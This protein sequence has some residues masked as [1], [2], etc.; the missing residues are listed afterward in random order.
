MCSEKD[1]KVKSRLVARGYEEHEL[2]D[3]VDS[4]T[5]SKSNLRLVIAITSAKQW[6]INSLDFHSAFLQGE[7][8]TGDIFIKPPK[9]ANT[10]CLWKL[11]KH[12]YGLKQASRKWYNRVSSELLCSG[13]TKSKMDEALFFLHRENKLKGLVAGHVDD[14][15]WSGGG[16]LK[17]NVIDRLMDTFRISSDLHDSFN[18]LGLDIQQTRD[19]IE[20]D[21]SIYAEGIQFVPCFDKQDKFRVLSEEEK[22]PLRSAIGQLCWIANQ[23][24]PDSI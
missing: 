10:K 5:C 1:G 8:V 16:E 9:E 17:E 23:T 11:N 14:F 6:R 3:R 7:E 4:P 12:V 2:K 15:F 22:I 24:R 20:I 18:F 19:A 13:L 21:Q